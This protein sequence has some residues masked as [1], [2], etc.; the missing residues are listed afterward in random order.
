MS[1]HLS[2]LYAALGS[3]ADTQS[4]FA[5]TLGFLPGRRGVVLATIAAYLIFLMA[6]VIPECVAKL[7]GPNLNSGDPFLLELFLTMHLATF[8]PAIALLC[9]CGVLLQARDVVSRPPELPSP[10]SKTGLCLQAVVFGI[11]AVLWLVELPSSPEGRLDQLGIVRR[12]FAIGDGVFAAGQAL[13]FLVAFGGGRVG[14]YIVAMSAAVLG[15]LVLGRRI[16]GH[17]AA[18]SGETEPLL[19][20]HGEVAHQGLE[21]ERSEVEGQPQVDAGGA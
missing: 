9:L 3:A 4:R 10:L 2:P 20:Q 8:T 12:W 14:G 18:S 17:V 6:S 7:M 19:G 13:L 21:G 16:L 1:A 5:L 15:W 11:M